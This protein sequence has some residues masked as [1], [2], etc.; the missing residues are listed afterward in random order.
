MDNSFWQIIS[1]CSNVAAIIASPLVALYIADRINK[2][3]QERERKINIFRQ[4]MATRHQ[5]LGKQHVEALNMIHFEFSQEKNEE[6]DVYEAWK[7]LH[8]HFSDIN[9]FGERTE[10]TAPERERLHLDLL[11]K[12]AKCLGYKFDR[13]II[14]KGHYYPEY[15]SQVDADLSM[16]RKGLTRIFSFDTPLFPVWISNLHPPETNDTQKE[17]LSD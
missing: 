5:I 1:I 4:L 6:R 12:M 17:T 7:E 2:S 3:N 9:N 11:S 14:N 10:I 13:V 8:D 15:L 16:I